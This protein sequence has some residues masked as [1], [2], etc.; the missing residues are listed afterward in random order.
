MFFGAIMDNGA[1]YYDIIFKLKIYEL[2]G[3]SFEDFFTQ[4]MKAQDDNFQ[5]VKASGRSGDKSCDGLNRVTGDYFAIYAPENINDSNTKSKKLAKISTDIKG[6]LANWTDCKRIYYVIND[7]FQGLPPDI[8]QLI[9]EYNNKIIDSNKTIEIF[10]ME[11]LKEICL[12]LKHDKLQQ[13]LGFTPDLS[14]NKIEMKYH[15][16][17]EIIQY[18][19]KNSSHIIANNKLVV[20]DFDVK[21]KYNQLSNFIRDALNNGRYYINK[22]DEFFDKN[23]HYN[24]EELKNHLVQIYQKACMICKGNTTTQTDERFIFMW[25]T[26]CY[27]NF[28]TSS[29]IRNNAFVI[30]TLFFESCDIFEEPKE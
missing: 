18:L 29:T 9:D 24:K 6:L 19:D 17:N 23:S 5:K 27:G 10:S 14:K 26:I 22:I 30:L 25:K 2:S 12:S 15:I 7:K 1:W 16:I 28:D 8:L 20:P 21:I 3:Q 4:I 13:I 11:K